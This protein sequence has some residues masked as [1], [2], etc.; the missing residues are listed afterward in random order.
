[1][2]ILSKL[3]LAVFAAAFLSACA[4]E[5]EPEPMVSVEPEPVFTGKP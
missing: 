1:M 3:T 5:P 4:A 2:A